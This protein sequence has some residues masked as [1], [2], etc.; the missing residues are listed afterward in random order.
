VISA[1]AEAG[2]GVVSAPIGA[3]GVEAAASAPAEAV[4][5]NPAESVAAPL[6]GC[7][8]LTNASAQ[9]PAI[10]TAAA[11][12]W[13]AFPRSKVGPCASDPE[14]ENERSATGAIRKRIEKD[15]PEIGG[16]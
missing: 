6:A 3:I 5:S 9:V 7:A 2:T 14:A 11:S 15:R 10:P 8:T 16:R 13:H 1:S 4:S 12:R